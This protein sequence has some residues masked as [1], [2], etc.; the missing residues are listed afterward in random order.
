MQNGA[1][2]LYRKEAVLA[3][4]LDDLRRFG[5]AIEELDAGAWLREEEMHNDI[6]ARLGFPDWYGANLDALR[7]CRRG[8]HVGAPGRADRDVEPEGMAPECPEFV[9]VGAHPC[10]GGDEAPGAGVNALPGSFPRGRGT[11]APC[12]LRRCGVARNRRR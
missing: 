9:T 7:E 4:D 2:V 8:L 1:V 6:A 12:L 11:A 10:F 5:Y 3:G